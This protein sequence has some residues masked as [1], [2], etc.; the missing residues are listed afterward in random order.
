[1]SLLDEVYDSACCL[2]QALNRAGG[3]AGNK[4]A[5]AA[6]TAASPPNTP[7]VHHFTSILL[8][9]TLY[10]TRENQVSSLM[11]ILRCFLLTYLQIE[12]ASLFEHNLK[13]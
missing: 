4:G 11:L 1:M 12:M 7:A 9:S 13:G 8:A 6:L 10:I 2:T 5:E 3:K